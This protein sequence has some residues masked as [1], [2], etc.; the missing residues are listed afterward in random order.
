MNVWHSLDP[1]F[2]LCENG[3]TLSALLK[4]TVFILTFI[5]VTPEY[6]TDLDNNPFSSY[7]HPFLGLTY[8]FEVITPIL[9]TKIHIF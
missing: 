5:R 9:Y 1:V 2:T 6:G 7:N 8:C 4:R 3:A